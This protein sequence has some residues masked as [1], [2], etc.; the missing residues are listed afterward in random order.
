MGGGGRVEGGARHGLDGG[1]R[2][3]GAAVPVGW[4]L[5]ILRAV[6]RPRREAPALGRAGSARADCGSSASAPPP[7]GGGRLSVAPLWQGPM[8]TA[9]APPTPARVPPLA[10]VLARIPP[11]QL[12]GQDSGAPL[13]RGRG[14]EARAE[15]RAALTYSPGDGE[16]DLSRKSSNPHC[17]A[18]GPPTRSALQTGS[19]T[20]RIL[21][22]QQAHIHDPLAIRP[23]CKQGTQRELGSSRGGGPP[24]YH[25]LR[26]PRLVLRR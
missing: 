10:A 25:C 11:K 23:S 26:V 5:E 13:T 16:R 22:Y 7:H 21:L 4:R 18:R 24:Q 12:R 15:K 17:E 19:T 6:R 9:P 3:G 2:V 20:A 1:R 14:S 8:A